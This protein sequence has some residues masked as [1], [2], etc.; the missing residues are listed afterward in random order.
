[1]QIGCDMTERHSA[2]LKDYAE[3]LGLAR[4]SLLALLIHR[5]LR[6]RSLKK[7]KTRAEVLN[8]SEGPK[9]VTFRVPD[10][11]MKEAFQEHVDECGIGSDDA[12]ATLFLQELKERWVFNDLSYFGN[13]G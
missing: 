9:R 12:A 4:P 5:E 7:L 2:E 1:M 11:E 3:S 6:E 8:A 13:R 10:E